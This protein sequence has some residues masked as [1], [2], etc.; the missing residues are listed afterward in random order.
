MQQNNQLQQQRRAGPQQ[1]APAATPQ[2]I[3]QVAPAKATPANSEQPGTQINLNR[4]PNQPQQSTRPPPS[5]SPAAPAK[6]LKR[7]NSD[8]VIEV[9]NPNAQQARVA[10]QAQNQGQQLR[11]P[12]Q[13]TSQQIAALDPEARKRYEAMM[14]RLRQQQQQGPPVNTVDLQKLRSISEEEA[15]RPLD[16][17]IPMDA[18]TKNSTAGR[19][20]SIVQSLT[21]VA[22]AIPRW[23]QITHDETRLR[24]FF[25]TVSSRVLIQRVL[26]LTLAEKSHSGTV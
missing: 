25:Q 20:K 13:L 24:M 8:D 2:M 16:P 15:K 17:P 19:L 6:N 11:Q 14:I 7:A 5:S 23:Y 21:N 3:G 4:Q 22:K 10:Q 12:P 18:Q 26:L 9:P 1:Q